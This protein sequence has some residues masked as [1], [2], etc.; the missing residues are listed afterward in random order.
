MHNFHILI[1]NPYRLTHDFKSN[2]LDHGLKYRPIPIRYGR[3]RYGL[4]CPDPIPTDIR[5]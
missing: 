2:Y 3:Y 1:I 5:Y 4:A